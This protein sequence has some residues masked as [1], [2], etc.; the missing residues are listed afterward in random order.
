M[1]Q[2]CA[3]LLLVPVALG[4]LAR[5]ASRRFDQRAVMICLLISLIPFAF[6]LVFAGIWFWAV[7]GVVL[8]PAVLGMW[9]LVSILAMRR[10][11]FR[12]RLQRFPNVFDRALLSIV[13]VYVFLGLTVGTTLLVRRLT[14]FPIELQ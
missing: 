3:L 12:T 4:L 5:L 9:L 8:V 10:P 6:I 1:L 7:G 2:E 13:M 14:G 11:Y